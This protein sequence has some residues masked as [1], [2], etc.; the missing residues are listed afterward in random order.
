VRQAAA[1][2][3]ANDPDNTSASTPRFKWT[4]DMVESLLNL[5]L[6]RF[7]DVFQGSKSNAQIGTYWERITMLFN[8][9]FTSATPVESQLLRDKYCKLKVLLLMT[10]G[11]N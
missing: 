6:G 4:D 11:M 1:L 9:K 5:R 2:A 10:S 7:K 8:R 3:S